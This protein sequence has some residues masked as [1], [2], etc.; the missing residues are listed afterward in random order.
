[1]IKI[2]FDPI[3]K[4]A[5]LISLSEDLHRLKARSAQ[6]QVEVKRLTKLT[7]PHFYDLTVRRVTDVNDDHAGKAAVALINID[8]TDDGARKDDILK[9]TLAGE[10]LIQSTDIESQLKFE[11]AQWSAI[12]TAIE[13]RTREIE[14]E[15]TALAIQ[16]SKQCKPRYDELMRRICKPM[17]EVQIACSELHSLRRHLIDNEMGFRGFG[18]SLPDFLSAPI[19]PYS[20]MATFFRSA[21]VEGYIKEVPSEL[22]A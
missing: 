14:T 13:F 16:Y 19:N 1:M 17:L 18:I 11:H 10:P 15:N 6:S 22:R 5:K 12:E 8:E 20:E 7:T 2:S 21:K 3:P 4:S 9:R